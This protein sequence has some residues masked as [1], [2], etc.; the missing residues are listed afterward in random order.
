MA[1]HKENLINCNRCFF[2]APSNVWELKLL[3]DRFL[4]CLKCRENRRERYNNQTE[5]A[6]DFLLAKAAKRYATDDDWRRQRI[7]E[8]VALRKSKN[9]MFWMR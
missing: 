1:E 8:V 5:E 9:Q 7:A 3:G 4:L 2:K 6:R